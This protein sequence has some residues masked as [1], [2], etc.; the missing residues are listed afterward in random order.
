MHRK[1]A[2]ATCCESDKNTLPVHGVGAGA[3]A[4]A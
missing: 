1:A 3:P 2:I 4:T